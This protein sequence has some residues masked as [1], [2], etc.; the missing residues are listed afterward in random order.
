MT[1][2]ISVSSVISAK[3]RYQLP[4]FGAG[5][6][7]KST[8]PKLT[9]SMQHYCEKNEFFLHSS[10]CIEVTFKQVIIYLIINSGSTLCSVF[11]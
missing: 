11:K 4:R 2:P 1:R 3:A 6:E 10:V 5:N 7:L 8:F 9:Q